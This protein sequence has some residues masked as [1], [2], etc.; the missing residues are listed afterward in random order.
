[1]CLPRAFSL[2]LF[3]Q[4][5][6]DDSDVQMR[7]FCERPPSLPL[8]L[9]PALLS[10]IRSSSRITLSFVFCFVTF[11]VSFLTPHSPR[12][13]IVPH[14]L[15]YDSLCLLPQLQQ[16]VFVRH[17]TPAILPLSTSGRRYHVVSSSI[18]LFRV[19]I[20][21]IVVMSSNSSIDFVEF[22]VLSAP[23]DFSSHFVAVAS[24]SRHLA[25]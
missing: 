13:P 2:Q 20:H 18:S 3:V 14:S 15:C 7:L 25:L 22:S 24:L 17:T 5:L 4:L 9:K 23:F 12:V 1:M 10:T 16:L 6:R 8:P 21:I 19:R 11:V